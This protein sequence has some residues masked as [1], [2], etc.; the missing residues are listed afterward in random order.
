M[1]GHAS[2]DIASQVAVRS[3]LGY[4]R[5]VIPWF[6]ASAL[7]NP[8]RESLPGV[9]QGLL[10]AVACGDVEVRRAAETDGRAGM[11][12][13]LTIA[14]LHYP[15]LYVAH[16]GDSRCYLLRK[17]E[18][19]QLTQDHTMAEAMRAYGSDNSEEAW[20]HVLTQALGGAVQAVPELRRARLWPGDAL[21]LC[22]DGVTAH[23][24]DEDIAE[25][26]RQ[27][28]TAADM[29]LNIV[30]EANARGGRDNITAVV[31]HV[32]GPADE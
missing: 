9:R 10:G 5:S 3:V 7:P 14:Y 12:T 29:C 24:P 18:L 31:A 17:S 15:Q 6:D 28:E 23:L 22:S 32:V 21:L 19:F 26:L 16:V 13:T 20:Q 25:M 11:G 1:G 8:H 27:P 2:G 4:L 30:N